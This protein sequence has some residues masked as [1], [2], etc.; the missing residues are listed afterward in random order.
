MDS[1]ERIRIHNKSS[2][3]DC[4]IIK[5]NR[6]HHANGNLTAVNNGIDLPFNIER[7]FY[8]YDVPGGGERGGH[9]HYTC[10]EFI[11]AVS[12]SFDVTIDDGVQQYTHTLNRPYQGL[13]VVPGIWRTLKN[14]SSGSVCLALCS[15]HFDEDDYVR[16][17]DQFLKLKA[18][19]T[20]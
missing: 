2:I 10:Q 16:E 17:Y 12:G 8:I 20:E 6:N 11:I 9:S 3:K 15:H 4:E 19:K 7:T 18:S 5:L 1:I 14:F 13:L